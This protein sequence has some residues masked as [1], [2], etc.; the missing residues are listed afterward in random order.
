MMLDVVSCYFNTHST[1]RTPRSSPHCHAGWRAKGGGE[2]VIGAIGVRNALLAKG[3][4]V[5][6]DIFLDVVIAV[7]VLVVLVSASFVYGTRRGRGQLRQRLI[8]LAARLG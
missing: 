8:A 1:G 7:V 2:A 3:G 6:H 4:V 5:L